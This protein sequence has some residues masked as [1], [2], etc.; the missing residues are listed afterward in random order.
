MRKRGLVPRSNI[1]QDGE[2][3]NELGTTGCIGDYCKVVLPPGTFV[4]AEECAAKSPGRTRT[5][6]VGRRENSLTS[7][8]LQPG[9]YTLARS[10]TE[11]HRK[12]EIILLL[13]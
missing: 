12:K 13:S 5:V 11:R 6:F 7:I 9:T 8:E 4:H 3:V 10:C 1:A 2:E